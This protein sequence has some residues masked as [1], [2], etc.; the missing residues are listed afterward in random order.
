MIRISSTMG[1][2]LKAPQR[3]IHVLAGKESFLC[4]S[5]SSLDVTRGLKKRRGDSNQL[6]NQSKKQ[7]FRNVISG[8]TKDSLESI[9]PPKNIE[10]DGSKIFKVN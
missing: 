5:T 8:S 4:A 10:N 2:L 1:L 6:K 3:T 7:T 9:R